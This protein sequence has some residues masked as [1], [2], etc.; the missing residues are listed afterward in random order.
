MM[1][2]IRTREIK[3]REGP[4]ERPLISY[5]TV[6]YN[7]ADSIEET[8][9]SIAICKTL[10]SC[11]YIIIDGNSNDGT[12]Q[13]LGRH[14]QA[15]DVLVREADLGVYDAMNKGLR[16]AK[17]E[18]VCFVNADDRIIPKGACKIAKMLQGTRR[19][20]DVVASAALA[21]EE[22]NETLW[23]P[24][25]PDRFLVFRCPNLCHNGV[26]AHRCLFSRVGKFDSGLQIAADS[27]WL[28]RAVRGGAR[29]KVVSTPTVFYRIG[30]ISSNI[31]LHAEE[32]LLV[33]QKTYPLLRAE[34][35]RSLFYYLFAWQERRSLFT[36][37]PSLRLADAIQEANAFYPE[38][39]YWSSL[40]KGVHQRLALKAYGKL[41]NSV[42]FRDR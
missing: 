35:I 7:S 4:T 26:Y 24:S 22:N 14:S 32:M 28:I 36:E 27:D 21:I 9:E 6:S 42:L 11:E 20:L 40:L 25:V 12:E 17:G 5:I 29:L 30:G 23:L 19:G 33:A 18:Y 15:I 41:R 1:D 38:L 39:S 13:I 16:L 10:F 8:I 31:S 37:Q 34:V 2:R 3:S